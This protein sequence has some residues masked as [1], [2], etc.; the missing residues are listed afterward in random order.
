MEPIV[1][2]STD[3]IAF[4]VR[5]S[6]LLPALGSDTEMRRC[7]EG[8]LLQITPLSLGVVDTVDGQR[9]P[10]TFRFANGR[11][12]WDH[13]WI[14]SIPL[15]LD[16]ISSLRMIADRT[17]P[18]SVDADSILLVNGDLVRGFIDGIDESIRLAPLEGAVEERS[19]ESIDRRATDAPVTDST[20][21]DEDR[22]EG[23][24]SKQAT[25]PSEHE[26]HGEHE[27][28]V[29]R[30]PIER[31]A[32]L[33]LAEMPPVPRKGIDIWTS[34]GS[35]VAANTLAFSDPMGWSFSLDSEWLR[36]IRSR[37]TTDNQ[38]ADP[39]AGVLDRERFLP[40]AN[41]AARIV[42]DTE[43]TSFRYG[44]DRPPRVRDSARYLLGCTEIDIEGPCA[45]VFDV[46]DGFTRAGTIA[47]GMIALKEPCSPDARVDLSIAFCGT[48]LDRIVLDGSNRCRVFTI[49]SSGDAVGEMTISVNDGG[50]GIAG[51]RVV[52]ERAALIAPR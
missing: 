36:A 1:F 44:K 22:L 10:G 17:V 38:A 9:L 33:A 32:A 42:K 4:V 11:P 20:E 8:S 37:P 2:P 46:P 34:D 18:A 35:V 51:D 16:R 31:V 3:V 19:G 40:L 27:G 45:I 43:S 48:T 5:R 49:R 28:G 14:G 13:R 25:Q 26:E 21:S 41:C 52:I 39:L 47:T 23:N 15:E 30:I 50:N 24:S 7:V 29:R 12:L 6:P